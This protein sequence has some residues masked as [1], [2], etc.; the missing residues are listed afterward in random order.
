MYFN[1]QTNFDAFKFVLNTQN[2]ILG[3]FIAKFSL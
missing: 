1:G 2:L 3:I